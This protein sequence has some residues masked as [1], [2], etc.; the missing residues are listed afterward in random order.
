MGEAMQIM[1]RLH[2]ERRMV[3][4]ESVQV[5]TNDSHTTSLQWRASAIDDNC[6]TVT[7]DGSTPLEALA[8]LRDI[9]DQPSSR[10]ESRG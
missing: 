3:A 5:A 4:L 10:G 8:R 1:E 7:A 9:V 6:D 2:A